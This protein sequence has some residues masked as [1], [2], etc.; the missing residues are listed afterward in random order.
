M[1]KFD[2]PQSMSYVSLY[3]FIKYTYIAWRK[4]NNASFAFATK[5]IGVLFLNLKL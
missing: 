4:T 2:L 3:E 1:V 5:K